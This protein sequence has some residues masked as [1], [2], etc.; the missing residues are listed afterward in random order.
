[1]GRTPESQTETCM[2]GSG[3]SR[4]D[5]TGTMMESLNTAKIR[6]D[7]GFWNVRTMYDTG[8][9]AQVISEMQRYKLSILGVSE[10]RWTGSGRM[11]TSSGETILYSGRDDDQ[12]H[13]G[14]AVILKKEVEKCLMEWKPI[15]SRLLKVRLRG[16]QTNISLIQC[17]APTNCAD[18]E[19]KDDFYSLLQRETERLPCH[20][21][22]IIIGDLNAK[23]GCDNTY[24]Q[25]EMGKHGCGVMNENGSR[26]ADF[27]ALHN[28]IIGGT[29]FQHREIHKLT[30]YSP[31][32][33]DRNQIDH[34]LINS[35]WTRS[36]Q[37][38]KVRRGADVG[39]DHQLVIAKIK[40]KLKKQNLKVSNI[41]KYDIEKLKNPRT[42]TMFSIEL[43]NRF[44]ALQDLANE[45][46]ENTDYI[47]DSWKSV[48]NIYKETSMKCLGYKGIQKK[49]EWLQPETWK[50]IEE[51]R[52][53]KKRYI[54]SKSERLRE[55]YKQEYS[56]AQ[57]KVKRMARAD[58]RKN[59]NDLAEQAQEAANK[60]EQGELYK[61]TKQI[62]GKFVSSS[63]GPVKDKLGNLLTTEN[64]IESR[65]TEHFQELLNR[66]IPEDIPEISEPEIDLDINLEPPTKE[67]II[68]AIRTLK[69]KKAPG[70]DNLN[71]ELF[72]TD[73]YLSANILFKPFHDIWV[74]EKL[75]SNW[76]I[77]KIVKI[78]KKGSLNDCNNWRGITLLSVP[79]KIMAKIIMNR[80]AEAVD[81]ILRQ[82]QAGFR[83]NR[84]CTDQIFVLRNIIEQC[85]EW[86][87]K[88]YINFID[89]QKAFDSL[90]RERERERES[91]ENRVMANYSMFIHQNL[92]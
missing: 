73:P 71:A 33:R 2:T 77:G 80:I 7:I 26:L 34:I 69:N 90:N 45:N 9:L 56:E 84:G 44:Q 48:E 3:Q 52:D 25:R 35:K 74:G 22:V 30:W 49:K 54:D 37:D 36:L 86:Q 14:V 89:F 76:N 46:E 43:K 20:D 59:I 1:M 50:A 41:R 53:A 40:L 27:C 61:I 32:N 81:H 67:E 85:T 88:L 12:H 18:E 8:R 51:R 66:P 72:K 57:R 65:W 10:C 5:A 64:E 79:S 83:R 78:H 24:Y 62:C 42:K 55:R 6:L 47:E 58:K 21:L 17:Y 23:V 4:Q 63:S 39:S 82:E 16:K 29:L 38:V 87:R 92:N 68:L 31:N 70:G 19:E 91:Q 11:K 60:G 15:S 75:P 28:L 13:E